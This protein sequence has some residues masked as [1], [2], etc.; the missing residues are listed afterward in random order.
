LIHSE[1]G[2]K[3]SSHG[4]LKVDEIDDPATLLLF[5]SS[6]IDESAFSQ[7][8]ASITSEQAVQ[9]IAKRLDKSISE[10][11]LFEKKKLEFL[12]QNTSSANVS[13]ETLLSSICDDIK[14]WRMQS[15]EDVSGLSVSI[16]RAHLPSSTSV[17]RLSIHAVAVRTAVC[18]LHRRLEVGITKIRTLIV[19]VQDL[20]SDIIDMLTAVTT[21]SSVSS[22]WITEAVSRRKQTAEKELN[23]IAEAVEEAR[24][25][26]EVRISKFSIA[27]RELRSASVSA[28]QE[29]AQDLSTARSE[30]T[31]A[32][33]N[34]KAKVM[35]CRMKF[36]PWL[37][38]ILMLR[39]QRKLY[40]DTWKRINTSPR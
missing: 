8:S 21:S 40:F 22:C 39:H 10:I 24:Q 9:S 19:R 18:A 29:T 17:D 1:S 34:F 30:T 35:E 5:R 31:T 36:R 7:S 16:W 25:I 23:R 26:I 37:I 14:E 3:Q 11:L 28:V 13:L 33:E 15:N 38:K 4:T 27:L 12:A 2:H 6:T 32:V 20:E